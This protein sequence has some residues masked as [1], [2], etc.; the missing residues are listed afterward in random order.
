MKPRER[1]LLRLFGVA[2]ALTMIAAVYL[3]FPHQQSAALPPDVTDVPCVPELDDLALTIQL[4]IHYRPPCEQQYWMP[5]PTDEFHVLVRFNNFGLHAPSYTLQKPS[6]VYRVLIVGDSFPQAMQ[7]THEQAFPQLLQARLTRDLGRPVEVI[8]LSVDGYGT[9]LELLVY[10]T[11]GWQF[12]PDLVLL[13]IYTGNDL[14]DNQID[15]ETRRYGYPSNRPFFTLTGGNDSSNLVGTRHA[16]SLLTMH[17][18]PTFDPSR[19]PDSP[20]FAWLTD[21]QTA[22]LPP[23][24]EN[25]PEHPHVLSEKPYA[26][27]Y[28]VELGLYLP[29]DAQW[30]NAWALTDA[31]IHQF[32]AV[33]E[34][35]GTP[36]AAF[37]IP[38]RRAVHTED[39]Q[40][41]LQDLA[42]TVPTLREADPLAPIQRLDQ[43]LDADQITYFDL[44]SGLREWAADNPGGRLYY[45][46]DGHFNPQG[47]AVTTEL[48]AHWLLESGLIR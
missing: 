21:M 23:P 31:L 43:M 36:F 47:H 3:I 25:P 28:P 35:Q 27:E 44:T 17:K 4:V 29:E 7:V 45:G 38:D 12:Q 22:Q 14:Q 19:Y 8:N 6:G 15:L 13:S 9:D 30:K 20:A 26:L 2:L 11:L 37:I 32:R 34:A 42:P 48:L 5:N 16:S 39:W 24:P 41:T 18:S 1:W 10:A 40:K 46:G 33:V